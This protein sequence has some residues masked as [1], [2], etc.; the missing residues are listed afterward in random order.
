MGP[1]A[2]WT[3][4]FIVAGAA[5]GLAEVAVVEVELGAGILDERR[6]PMSYPRT[7]LN[8]TRRFELPPR[9]PRWV[10]F[11]ATTFDV[12]ATSWTRRPSHQYALSVVG[13]PVRLTIAALLRIDSYHAGGR[14]EGGGSGTSD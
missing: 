10:T 8:Q 1:C 13:I 4:M 12:T 3:F 6:S 14:C 2:P 5:A 9:K 11:R 7:R